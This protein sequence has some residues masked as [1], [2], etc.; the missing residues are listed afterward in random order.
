MIDTVV[1]PAC[2]RALRVPDTLRGQLVKCPACELTFTA[3]EDLESAP[4]R[5]GEDAPPREQQQPAPRPRLRDDDDDSRARP[6]RR[7]EYDDDDDQPP[8]RPYVAQPGKV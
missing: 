3:S 6:R 8:Q 4:R 5:A 2:R 1:C 7:R